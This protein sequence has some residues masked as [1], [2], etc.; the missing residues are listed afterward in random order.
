M[1]DKM[2]KK[3]IISKQMIDILSDGEHHTISELH[4]LCGPSCAVT[5]RFHIC[6]ARRFLKKDLDI[7]CVRKNRKHGYMLVRRFNME[8]DGSPH[9]DE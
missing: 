2:K 1:T 3:L 5:V 9:R 8:V 6:R 7:V 4:A